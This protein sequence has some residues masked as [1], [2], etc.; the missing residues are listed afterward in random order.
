[1]K[2]VNEMRFEEKFQLA[3]K[4]CSIS[5]NLVGKSMMLLVAILYLA[6]LNVSAMS[7]LYLFKTEENFTQKRLFS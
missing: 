5:A 3:M 4:T 2:P 1:M 7:F 6:L